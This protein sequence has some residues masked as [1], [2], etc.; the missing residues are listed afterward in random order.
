MFATR[1]VALRVPYEFTVTPA[2]LKDNIL[3]PPASKFVPVT[4]NAERVY[5][6]SPVA[7]EIEMGFGAPAVMVK[8]LA[9]V[10]VCVSAFVITILR[11]VK[12]A[13]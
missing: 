8:A 1:V 5:P 9:R 3:V 7:W 2:P 10:P 11:A 12:A 4:V 13:L 6:C